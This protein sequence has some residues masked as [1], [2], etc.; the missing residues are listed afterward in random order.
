[1]TLRHDAQLSIFC[2]DNAGIAIVIDR[3]GGRKVRRYYDEDNSLGTAA[4]AREVPGSADRGEA[5][6]VEMGGQDDGR[7]G[8]TIAAADDLAKGMRTLRLKSG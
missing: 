3:P 4:D 2:E 6:E 7:D 8:A 1:M 5:T